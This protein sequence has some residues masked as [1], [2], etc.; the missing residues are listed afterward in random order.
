[1]KNIVL[2]LLI[3]GHCSFGQ[4]KVTDTLIAPNGTKY[5]VSKDPNNNRGSKFYSNSKNRLDNDRPKIPASV[6]NYGNAYIDTGIEERKRRNLLLVQAY[7]EANRPIPKDTLFM[8]CK[9][10]PSGEIVEMNFYL[11]ANSKLQA[12][13]VALVEQTLKQKFIFKIDSEKYKEVEYFTFNWPL[14]FADVKKL[15]E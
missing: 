15:A 8:I 13:D 9:L 14:H 11:K 4:V 12:E 6:A 3:A 7:K 10:K 2:L 1:M 5:I